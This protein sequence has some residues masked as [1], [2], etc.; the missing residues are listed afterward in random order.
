MCREFTTKV[1]ETLSN[2]PVTETGDNHTK[3]V[4]EGGKGKEE[5]KGREREGGGVLTR[6]KVE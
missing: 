3:W 6:A 5:R 4:S 2:I 1:T